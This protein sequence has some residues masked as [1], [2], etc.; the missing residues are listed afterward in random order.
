L[1]NKYFDYDL[2]LAY[3]QTIGISYEECIEVEK[4]RPGGM[5]PL[6][7]GD[8]KFRIIDFAKC[9]V[10]KLPI[11]EYCLENNIILK[12]GPFYSHITTFPTAICVKLNWSMDDYNSAI[13]NLRKQFQIFEVVSEPRKFP[14]G[15]MPPRK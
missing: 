6:P 5:D 4:S 7:P 10:C 1:K 15:A 14:M 11:I 13:N 2:Y 3:I 9:I 8:F 12:L